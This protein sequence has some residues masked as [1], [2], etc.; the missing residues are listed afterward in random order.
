MKLYSAIYKLT[1]DPFNLFDEIIQINDPSEL[2]PDGI[3][4]LH[5]GEDISPAIYQQRPVH[6][7][8]P[9]KPSQRD[10]I[11]MRMIV[12]ARELNMPIIGICRGAQLLCAVLGGKLFQHVT[13]HLCTHGIIT[14]DGHTLLASADHHQVMDLRTMK[15]PHELLAWDTRHVEAYTDE[16]QTDLPVVPEVVIFPQAKCL[17]IQPHPEW[18]HSTDKFNTWCTEQINKYLLG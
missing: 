11:E 4:L 12:R 1:K 10:Y 17:A 6:T 15:E 16:G 18:M 9:S 3:L 2:Q 7:H 5:G 8:A 13:N 14:Y